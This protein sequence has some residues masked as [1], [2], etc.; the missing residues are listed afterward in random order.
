MALSCKD[1][2]VP[3]LMLLS[4]LEF[5][6]WGAYLTSIGIYLFKV[7]LGGE[8][9]WFFA[10]Q[11]IASIFMPSAMG[12]I[13][14]KWLPAEKVLASCHALAA[15]FMAVVG[16]TGMVKGAD[17]TFAELFVPYALSVAFFM[18][19]VALSNSVSFIVLAKKGI[20]TV[21]V[22]PRIR[23]LGTVGFILSMWMTDLLGFK[24]SYC[25]FFSAAVLGSVM[26]L[27]SLTIP[28]CPP[29]GSGKGATFLSRMGVD[30]FSLL[31]DKR[32]AVFFLFAVLLGAAL[33]VSNGYT[34]A[35][36]GSF[37]D[38]PEYK[39]TFA[40]E[41]PVIMTSLS[42]ISETLCILLIPFFLKRYG[43]KKVMIIAMLAWVARFLLL[44][45]G[46]PAGGV[47]MF[48]LS[49]AVYGV[50]FDFFNIS[51]SLYV[52]SRV[53]EKRRSGAQGLFMLAANGLGTFLGMIA[54]Q[55]IVN[56]SL[57]T[58][59]W[60]MAWSVFAAYAAL[61]AVLFAL[62]FKDDK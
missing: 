14:D 28:S 58:G 10:V 53:D 44:G 8:I 2:T 48:V 52:N 27:Y 13:A 38:M 35:Y 11:G 3:R 4:F 22:F 1:S 25:Q 5:G 30:A 7:G 55:K 57:A 20:D 41:H 17:V 56:L 51:G 19:T 36:L 12:C 62:F 24:D 37:A 43:I 32:M 39:G 59:G 49:M 60:T 26:A 33:Q 6:I 40:V 54:A 18:P 16:Y 15:V 47:W 31:A 42:Q 46:N 45:I 61:M 21:R 50:A 23:V 9:G 34:G 29:K